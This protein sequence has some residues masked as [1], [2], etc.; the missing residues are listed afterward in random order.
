[1]TFSTNESNIDRII[2]VILGALLAVGGLAAGGV[3][4]VIG[5]VVGA[6]LLFTAV[7]GWCPIYRVL[8]ISTNGSTNKS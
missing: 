1:M 8:G 2:R 3:L 5:V 7:V 4:A 6:I